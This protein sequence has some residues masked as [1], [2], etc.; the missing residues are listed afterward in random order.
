MVLFQSTSVPDKTVYKNLVVIGP[1]R[2]M[3][4]TP[5]YIKKVTP[6]YIL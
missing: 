2:T 3:K 4:L 5:V 1:Q 6:V